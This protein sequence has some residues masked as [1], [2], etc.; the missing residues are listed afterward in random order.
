MKVT[1]LSINYWP[2]L[3][4]IA[5][6]ATDLAE[7]LLAR[8][9]D[10]TV[11]TG[12]PHYPTRVIPREYRGRI[13]AR[14]RIRGVKVFRCWLRV[15]E[16][17]TGLDKILHH[18]TFAASCGMGILAAGRPEV[19]LCISPPLPLAVPAMA[20]SAAWGIPH[21]FCVQDLLPE[22]AVTLGL[23]RNPRL[24]AAMERL[25]RAAYRRASRVVV[26]SE[27]F[28]RNLLG[29]G[30][31]EAKIDLVYNWVDTDRVRPSER[32]NAWRHAQGLNGDP[33][34]LYAGNM[35]FSQGLDRVVDAAAMLRAE[36]VKFLFVGDGTQKAELAARMREGDVSNAHLLPLVPQERFPEILAA[37]DI[38]LVSQKGNVLDINLPSKIP[39]YLAAGRPMIA[40]VN[41][42]GDAA[43]IA[44]E[45][46]AAV[47]VPPE[48]PAA[49]AGAV[50]AL[51]ADPARREAM[52]RAARAY[53]EAHFRR[54]PA[55]AR[56][57]ASM[58]AA[59]GVSPACNASP[60]C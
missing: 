50:R 22:A 29:K 48:D 17:R 20:A 51:L 35:G 11:V 45:C 6:L 21:L 52:S 55:V 14:E 40:A 60:V 15:S 24:I 9:H 44:R 56:Y 4:G 19:L 43:R 5:P 23:L 37:A 38:L 16:E 39:A 47:W 25:E 54:G 3:T 46:G 13:F 1:I 12:F 10:V 7:G 28:R 27:G 31:P 57:E 58:R 33:V 34:V 18:G 8:G 53:A 2:E 41:P 30:V 36:G 32:E 49:L 26:I 59:L 42:N